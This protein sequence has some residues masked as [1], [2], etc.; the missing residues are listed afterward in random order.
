VVGDLDLAQSEINQ[1]EKEERTGHNV[2]SDF[3][4]VSGVPIL[5]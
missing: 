4:G 1:R 2:L 3:G 5:P